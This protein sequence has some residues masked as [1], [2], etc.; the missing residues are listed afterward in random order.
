[1][2]FA[3]P[4]SLIFEADKNGMIS[5]DRMSSTSRRNTN[6]AQAIS[7]HDKRHRY[8]GGFHCHFVTEDNLE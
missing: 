1:V 4:N 8:S 5:D 3:D 7:V 6:L 2:L